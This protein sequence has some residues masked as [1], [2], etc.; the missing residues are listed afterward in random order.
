MSEVSGQVIIN[1]RDNS[2]RVINVSSEFFEYE[3]KGKQAQLTMT[4]KATD[5][6][7][8][9]GEAYKV[10]VIKG[11]REIFSFTFVQNKPSI[12]EKNVHKFDERLIKKQLK[13]EWK[14]IPWM[15]KAVISMNQIIGLVS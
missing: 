1:Y 14:N 2:K 15:G 3:G 5:L 8:I 13:R 6:S 12:Q 10:A 7:L 4:K 9:G 11:D